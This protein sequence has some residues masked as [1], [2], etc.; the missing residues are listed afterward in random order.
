MVGILGAWTV[1]SL[2]RTH[3]IAGPLVKITRYIHQ[4]ATGNFKDRIELRTGDQ[5]QALARA[6]NNMAGSLEERDRAIREETL[7][8]IEAVRCS[9]L[10]TPSAERA[11]QTLERLS[12]GIS[13]SF[14]EKWEAPT[15]EEAP[16][17]PV[18]S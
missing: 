4:F 1:F 16:K 18:H 8:Q 2:W 13:H 5:M 17:E 14:D 6:L 7:D 12:E 11:I 10:D 15:P 3:K 9:L